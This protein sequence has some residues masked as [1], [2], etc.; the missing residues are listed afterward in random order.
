M[1]VD[2]HLYRL[3]LGHDRAKPIETK[4]VFGSQDEIL[5]RLCSI[6]GFEDLRQE[7]CPIRGKVAYLDYIYHNEN[8][9]IFGV[10]FELLEDPVGFIMA[11]TEEVEDFWP[12]IEALKDLGPFLVQ[13]PEDDP[14]NPDEFFY[15]YDDWMQIKY[16]ER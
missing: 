3:S 7:Q 2:Y 14:I 15:S 13:G 4:L 5:D 6:I 12:I 16:E 8:D 9:L 11:E 10:T 1:S